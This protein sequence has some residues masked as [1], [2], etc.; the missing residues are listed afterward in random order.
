[1]GF[2]FDRRLSRDVVTLAGPVI[3]AMLTQTAINLVDTI[4]VGRLPTSYSIAGQAAI[5][6]SLIILWAFTGFLSALSVG[7]QAITAR[8]FG[9][10][11]WGLAGRVLT[12]S[13]VIATL[14]SA[15]VTVIGWVAMPAIFGLVSRNRDVIELGVSYNRIRMLS[16]IAIVAT[17]SCKS[18]FDGIG[19]TYVHM[20]AAIVM[21]LSNILLNYLLMYGIW[22]FPKLYVDGAAW[23]SMISGWIGLII[24]IAWALK[25]NYRKKYAFGHLGNLSRKVSWDIVRISFPSGLAVVFVMSGFALFLL[26]VGIVDAREVRDT[27]RSFPFYRDLSLVGLH[28]YRGAPYV[29]D[30]FLIVLE[31]APPLYSAATKIIIDILSISFMSCLAFGTATATL[32]S[33]SLGRRDPELAER[34]GWESVKI[35]V[36]LMGTLG[37]VAILTPDLLLRIFSK[38]QSVIDAARNSLRLMGLSE[39][40]IAVGMIMAQALYGA[41]NSKFVMYA[42]ALLHGVLLVPLSYAL[43]IWLDWGMF[44]IWV[45]ALTYMLML[46]VVMSWKFR[47]GKWKEIQI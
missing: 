46:A 40:L 25:A 16:A 11:K 17:A 26:I 37:L 2:G 45:A 21:N 13:M 31:S 9:E 15:I 28:M 12:N 36:V 35:G 3:L 30:P 27:V 8:R 24:I 42:E 18:W 43:G 38:D 10:E 32:V 29:Q 23:G 22:I 34:Y 20:V 4:M 41:G 47:E 19:R 39:A 44:G 1:M 7:T 14:S 6:L 33:Q 5:A